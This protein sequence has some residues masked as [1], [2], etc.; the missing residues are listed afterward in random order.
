MVVPGRPL[1]RES[2]AM[3]W[4]IMEIWGFLIATFLV[5]ALVGWV[6]G[7]RAAM[8]YAVAGGDAGELG[9]GE[10]A[11]RTGGMRA[12]A[13]RTSPPAGG[14]DDLT[15]IIGVAEADARRLN[16]LGVFHW[17]DIAGWT[18]DNIRWIENQIGEP[19]RVVRER[20]VEQASGLIGVDDI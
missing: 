4:L 2:D 11:V 14:G 5:G 19:G 3:I 17:R 6:V 20:W 12:P 16:A 7:R 1:A 9:A 18:D 8:D 15:Q 10:E 13:L